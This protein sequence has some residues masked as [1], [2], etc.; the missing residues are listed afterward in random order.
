MQIQSLPVLVNRKPLYANRELNPHERPTFD[1]RYSADTPAPR[2]SFPANPSEEQWRLQS[3]NARWATPLANPA[4]LRGPWLGWMESV[5]SIT[6]GQ[7]II[8]IVHSHDAVLRHSPNLPLRL[9]ECGGH[10]LL[11]YQSPSRRRYNH[12]SLVF[13]DCGLVR[14]KPAD[15][16]NHLV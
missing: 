8:S 2:H 6:T 11:Q 9:H 3:T 16:T 10:I 4:T 15:S 14:E 5:S 1:H 7:S 12:W 13:L